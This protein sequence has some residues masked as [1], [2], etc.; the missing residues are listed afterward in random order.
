MEATASLRAGAN[1]LIALAVGVPV[2]ALIPIVGWLYGWKG[3]AAV[4]ALGIV[5]AYLFGFWI[6]RRGHSAHILWCALSSTLPLTLAAWGIVTH[7][8]DP[9]GW[10]W[11]CAAALT[12]VAALIGARTTR[13]QSAT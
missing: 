7:A 5:P 6:A 13:S 4:V 1:A 2:T 11:L 3:A 8:G 12:F 10:F 9:A